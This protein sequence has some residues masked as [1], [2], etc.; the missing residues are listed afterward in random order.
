MDPI[1]Y[2]RQSINSDDLAMVTNTMGSDFLTQG[3]KINEFERA[4]E[5]ELQVNHA[6]VCS[7]GTAALHLSYSAVGINSSSLGIVPAI[8]FAATANALRY[9]GADVRICDVDPKTGLICLD[10]LKDLIIKTSK[11]KKNDV[12]L[13]APVSF[14][15]RVAPLKD[16]S[17]IAEKNNFVVIEDASHSP[18]AWTKTQNG[19]CKSANGEF[20]IAST[21]SFHPV[22]HIC[23]GEGGA[24]VTNDKKLAEKAEKL[25]SHGI[26]RP[27]D[28]NDDMPWY[29]EQVDLGWNYRLTD[30]QASLG[31]SQIKRLDYFLKKRKAIAQ[32]YDEVLS[33]DPYINHITT[34]PFDEGHA[35]HLYV[36]SFLEKNH[37]NQAYKFLK[38]KKIFT[39]IHYIPVYKHPYYK[40]LL[41]SMVLP[42]SEEYF[43]S[44]LSI[45]LYP[46]MTEI[47]QDRVLETLALF[48]EK[49]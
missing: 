19:V 13:I 45:P 35:W 32:R 3:P 41:G 42:G 22:K 21:L 12:N 49:G 17:E 40:N 5:K 43:E 47:E 24:V 29:Y 16:C 6:V 44:C 20:A 8:T 30:I 1:P 2:S 11:E 26:H 25:R 36:I 34:P 31:I 46:D 4:I 39:Q 9:Q 7:S 38:E 37:R 27:Y 10:S 14:A 48:L 18:G 33:K 28:E 23:A 15:G